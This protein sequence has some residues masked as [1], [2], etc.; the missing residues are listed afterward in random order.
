M[1]SNELD[2]RVFYVP[3]EDE[4]PIKSQGSLNS[5]SVSSMSVVFLNNDYSLTILGP[6]RVFWDFNRKLL[7][8]SLISAVIFSSFT[9]ATFQVNRDFAFIGM[10]AGAISLITGCMYLV[11]RN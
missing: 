9:I 10:P 8:I 3:I 1:K 6:E 5:R 11:Y 4:G 2:D 7:V